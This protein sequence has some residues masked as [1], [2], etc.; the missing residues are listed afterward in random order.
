MVRCFAPFGVLLCFILLSPLAHAKRVAVEDAMLSASAASSSALKSG[1]SSSG[2]YPVETVVL[3]NG[4]VKVKHQQYY[5][6]TGFAGAG[7]L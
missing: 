7:S 4:K 6:G 2:F 3:P 1:S 5:L